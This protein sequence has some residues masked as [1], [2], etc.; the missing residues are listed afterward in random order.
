MRFPPGESPSDSAMFG[1]T[2]KDY[3]VYVLNR[4]GFD[5]G[6]T[7][8]GFLPGRCGF[9]VGIGAVVAHGIG[10]PRQPAVTDEAHD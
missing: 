2:G 6:L 9:G 3:S 1:R 10:I 7:V 4:E 8:R 5:C